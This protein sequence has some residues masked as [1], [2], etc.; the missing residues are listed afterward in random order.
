MDLAAR[1][2]DAANP[3]RET[4]EPRGAAASQDRWRER[5]LLVCLILVTVLGRATYLAHD[6][7]FLDLRAGEMERAA[8][9]LVQD[10]T[11][12]R[13]YSDETGKSAHV[14]PLYP[15]LLAG[16]YKIFGWNTVAGR[17]AQEA[18]AVLATTIG[19]A[20]LPAVARAARL[21]AAAGWAAA[22]AMAVLPLNLWVETSGSWEQP[23]AAVALL[24]MLLAFGRLSDDG[25]RNA[26]R[27]LAC[28]ALLGVVALLSPAL[29]PAG[30]LM[31]AAEFPRQRGSRKRILAGA[32]VMGV[33]AGVVI[34]PWVI[35]NYLALGAFIP[36]RSNFG[37]E[38]AFGNNPLSDGKTFPWGWGS[39]E[40]RA[41][42]DAHPFR[43]VAEWTRLESMGEAAYMRDK[44]REALRW[45]AANPGKALQLTLTRF[46]L[47]WFP[48]ADMWPPESSANRLKSTLNSFFGA[49]AL[50]GLARLAV[51]GHPRAWL[52]AAAAIGP[53]LIYMVTHV[54]TRYRYPTFGLCV[55][56]SFDL[57]VAIWGGVV[58][59]FG[60]T[61]ASGRIADG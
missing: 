56:L 47:Y 43:N 37:L 16:L 55:L 2:V 57:L 10:G 53:S 4:G 9:S 24:G 50:L 19:I 26:R 52:L 40:R 51:A 27:L 46:R 36:L 34:S 32:L 39:P 17:M 7:T 25:W 35:R 6:Q 1:D 5:T 49:A 20:L 41:A 8:S 12:S 15:F 22:F 54:D 42:D 18:L 23:L 30:A 61:A 58:R 29:L 13:I 60:R 48:S 38:L 44:Q 33:V 11:I 28:G 59:R 45:M 21:S 14:A 3:S 31:I